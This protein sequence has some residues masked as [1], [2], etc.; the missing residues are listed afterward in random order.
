MRA[1][2][3]LSFFILIVTAALLFW[4]ALTDLKQ[5]KI[6]NDF[7]LVLAGL[8]FVQAFVSGRFGEIPWHLGLA[9]VALA[10]MLYAYWLQQMGG[11]DLKLLAACFLW[12]GPQCGLP[13][14]LL[15]IV[16]IG[17]HYAAARFGW[18]P[19]QKTERGTWV[20]LAPSAAGALIGTFM[21]GC[22]TPVAA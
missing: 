1:Y 6:R 14:C 13:F 3:F 8:Y 20:P 18:A 7:V 10:I 11:G 9:A 2:P 16:L 5:F 4:M 19:G 21:L 17:I 22:F 12:T 15:L